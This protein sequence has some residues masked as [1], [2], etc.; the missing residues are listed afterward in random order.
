[1]FKSSYLFSPFSK[2][3]LILQG[4][5][6]GAPLQLLPFHVEQLKYLGVILIRVLFY[7]YFLFL[8]SLLLRCVGCFFSFRICFLCTYLI[9]FLYLLCAFL[10]LPF[11][12]PHLRK[13]VFLI[14]FL[15]RFCRFI[16]LIGFRFNFRFGLNSGSK[17]KGKA[18]S[19]HHFWWFLNSN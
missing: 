6:D 7:F 10:K 3:D 14:Y 12:V 5:Q 15:D 13:N 17:G 18:I 4:I 9:V 2:Y 8:F 16:E 11:N 19:T 1:M